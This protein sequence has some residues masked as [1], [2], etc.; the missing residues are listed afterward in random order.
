V[1][2]P[3]KRH[4]RSASRIEDIEAGLAALA[5][6]VRRLRLASIAIPP[7][8]CGLGGLRWT[9][10]RPL[11]EQ[12]LGGLGD[13][14]VVVFEPGDRRETDRLPQGGVIPELTPGRAV[15]IALMEKYLAVLLDPSLSLLEVHKLMYFAQ[16]AG[17]PLR[18]SFVKARYG[19]YAQN[20]RHVL[21]RIEGHLITGYGDGG[22]DPHKELE[23]LP[24]AADRARAKLE[25]TPETRQRF[26][27][28]AKVIDGFESSFGMELLATVH[29]VMSREH[30][31]GPEVVAA[32]HRWNPKKRKFAADQIQ[33]AAKRLL[34]EGWIAQAR[35]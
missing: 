25:G 34:D 14:R 10:V 4:W 13:V 21:A 2:F 30:A 9:A 12:A 27:R 17:E 15:L 5:S 11:I 23:L 33:V 3:T 29:W 18:L 32:I 8:G 35:A 22:E 26:D 1:N 16:E 31:R 7:L 6:E 24:G 28:V 20:L 19:P